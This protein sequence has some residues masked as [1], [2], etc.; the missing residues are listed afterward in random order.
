[1]LWAGLK[2]ITLLRMISFWHFR[3][4]LW[5]IGNFGR[6]SPH[7]DYIRLYSWQ[8]SV[9]SIVLHP[10][11]GWNFRATESTLLGWSSNHNPISKIQIRCIPV[12][13]VILRLAN[14]P[15]VVKH[16]SHLPPLARSPSKGKEKESQALVPRSYSHCK[17][18]QSSVLLGHPPRMCSTKWPG[19][20]VVLVI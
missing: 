6:V 16:T 1:M 15:S 9:P 11:L 4:C 10:Q 20:S 17:H 8:A 3:L 18:R 5:N 12:G 7:L 19:W 13:T 2:L 14:I